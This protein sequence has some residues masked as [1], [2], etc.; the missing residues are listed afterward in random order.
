M[1]YLFP[2]FFF[3]KQACGLKKTTTFLCMAKWLI[4]HNVQVCFSSFSASDFTHS[5]SKLQEQHAEDL[6][7]LVEEF[8]HKN[9]EL[10]SER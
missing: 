8:R 6:H 1:F 2:F 7:N 3:F 5:L 10:R 9:A 4:F